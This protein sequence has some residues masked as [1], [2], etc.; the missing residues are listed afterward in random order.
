MARTMNRD[1]VN[2]LTSDF[3]PASSTALTSQHVVQ[4]PGQDHA[5]IQDG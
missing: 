4:T 3:F 1:M 2:T 5:V